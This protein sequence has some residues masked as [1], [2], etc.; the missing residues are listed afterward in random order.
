MI[1]RRPPPM[2]AFVATPVA[3]AP[4]PASAAVPT[5][6][7]VPALIPAESAAANIASPMA[8]VENPIQILAAQILSSTSYFKRGR[9]ASKGVP[10]FA[11]QSM[12]RAPAARAS[13]TVS[14]IRLKPTRD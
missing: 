2:M 12:R 13:F 11:C 3:I 5:A 10:S 9:R 1:G 4:A 6:L 14:R 8:A 7:T